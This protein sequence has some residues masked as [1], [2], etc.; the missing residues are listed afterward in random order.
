V[1][2]AFGALKPEYLL[3]P[4]R[5]VRRLLG[6]E[7]SANGRGAF[8]LP[9]PWGVSIEVRQLDDIAQVIDRL[10]VYD[11]V[12]TETIWRL[13]HPG[14]TVLDVGANIGFMSV[15][16]VARLGDRGRLV[17]FEPHPGLFEELSINLEIARLRFPGV[18][19]L[20]FCEAL[21]DVAG[22][23][24]L[25][26]PAE[27]SENRGLARL[28]GATDGIEVTT[29]RLDDHVAETGPDI[30]LM[31]IDVEGHEAA[32]FRGARALLERGAVRHVIMEEHGSFPTD[33]TSLLSGF[34]Y[35]FFSLERSIFG[36]RLGDPLG[37][38][39]PSGWEA[40]SLLATRDPD[41]A[42]AACKVPGWR[43]LGL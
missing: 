30:A 33:A 42:L 5:L 2:R 38:R 12:V 6:T 29:R 14:D 20:S 8:V 17:A 16:M 43:T 1:I 41:A 25:S 39:R 22:T 37:R 9:L 11:L 7:R 34:G 10:G 26:V 28:G 19:T 13:I 24:R 31:K 15:A 40:P 21:S 3:Q 36:P 32:V 23:A 27:F 35:T 18:K 4:G